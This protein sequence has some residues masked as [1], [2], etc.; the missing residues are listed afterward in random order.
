[1]ASHSRAPNDYS[2]GWI[3]ALP[4]EQTAAIAIHNI[5]IVYLPKGKIATSSAAKAATHMIAGFPSIKFGLMVGI[6][7]GIL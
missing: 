6:D 1:M 4:K 2:I 7:G 3:S 5:V